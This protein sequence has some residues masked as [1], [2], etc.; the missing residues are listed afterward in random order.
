MLQ[1]LQFSLLNNVKSL[2]IGLLGLL[3]SFLGQAMSADKNEDNL[4]AHKLA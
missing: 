3:L 4:S 1:K 2:I